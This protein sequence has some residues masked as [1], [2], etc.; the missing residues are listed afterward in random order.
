MYRILTAKAASKDGPGQSLLTNIARLRSLK[1]TGHSP[2]GSK[3]EPCYD[4]CV[5]EPLKGEV[6][7]RP[8]RLVQRLCYGTSPGT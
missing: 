7:S 3:H 2:R 6:G 1:E 5:A 8:D 4:Y